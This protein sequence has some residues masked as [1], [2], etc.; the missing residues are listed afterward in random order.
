MSGPVRALNANHGT[1]LTGTWQATF[2]ARAVA[3]GPCFQ[4]CRDSCIIATDN[5][6]QRRIKHPHLLVV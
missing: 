2:L 1:V 6:R 3:D 5:M 4:L